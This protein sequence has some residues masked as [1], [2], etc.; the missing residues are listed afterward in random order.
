LLAPDAIALAAFPA[1]V[2]I[3]ETVLAALDRAQVVAA[4]ILAFPAPKGG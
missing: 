4:A 1:I 3:L 2:L